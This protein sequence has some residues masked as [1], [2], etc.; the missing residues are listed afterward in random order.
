MEVPQNEHRNQC[1]PDLRVHR[2]GTGP[3]ERLDLQILLDS[4][5][6]PYH[7]PAVL[8]DR[9]DRRQRVLGAIRRRRPLLGPTFPTTAFHVRESARHIQVS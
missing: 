3:Q 2:I 7:L 1:R 9:G 6:E 8:I 4:L 5:E